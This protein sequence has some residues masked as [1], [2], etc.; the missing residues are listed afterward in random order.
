MTL[1]R[2]GA[3]VAAVGLILAL[4]AFACHGPSAPASPRVDAGARG[5]QAKRVSGGTLN[6]LMKADFDHLDP[7]RIYVVDAWNFSRLLYRTLTTYKAVPG[8]AGAEIVGDMATN[9]G[10]P[11]DGGKTWR[12]RLKDGLNYEDGTDVKAEDIKYGVERAFDPDL[13]EGPQY[14]QQLLADVPSGYKGPKKSGGKELHSIVVSGKDITFRLK[15]AVGDFAYTMSLP[16]TAPVPRAKDTGLLYDKRVFSSGPYKIDTYK[17]GTNL[18][19]VRNRFWDETTDQVRR[20][21]PDR[22]VCS[23]GLDPATIDQRLI[24]NSGPDT[25]AIDLDTML[26]PE[27]IPQALGKAA[28]KARTAYGLTGGVRYLAINTA[29]I[30][31]VRV[32][33]AINYGVNRRA[34]RTAR[35][36]RY[37][38]EYATTIL[39]PDILGHKKYDLYPAQPQGDAAKAKQLLQQ[40]G[41]TLPL[42]VT[43][44]TTNVGTGITQAVA[45][46]EALKRAG[47]EVTIQQTAPE[48]YFTTFGGSKQPE[49]AFV[50]WSPDWPSAGA[51]LPSL[52][53][54]RQIN[55]PNGHNYAQFSD[56]GVDEQM[57]RIGAMT[58]RKGKAKAWGELDETI[59]RQAPVVPLLYS[60]GIQMHGSKVHGAYLHSYFGTFDMVSLSAA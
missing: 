10:V 37:V 38:G 41:V 53:D 22:I 34:Y 16:T 1:R 30:R 40:A 25:T 26:S 57:D 4:T 43:L 33:R 15:K 50:S 52:F 3:K 45:V 47:I 58:N 36:G 56:P 9:T 35:G 20:S 14:I 39:A 17:R 21:Y 13:P 18:T 6:V 29:K 31:D 44:S 24:A 19:L 51:V 49:L 2:S 32:R 60:A 48:V 11:S 12:F 7:A 59:M 27:S 54:G 28:T 46:Q 55:K 23:F 5:P 8:K 42:R